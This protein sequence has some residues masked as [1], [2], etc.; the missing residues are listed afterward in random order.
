MKFLGKN[1][2]QAKGKLRAKTFEYGVC[3]VD[4]KISKELSVAELG[5]KT[6]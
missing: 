5:E 3:L 1:T 4:S 6:R 2:F